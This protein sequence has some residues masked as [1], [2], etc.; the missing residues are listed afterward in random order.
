M[1]LSS[2][3]SINRMAISGNVTEEAF[4]LAHTRAVND[5]VDNEFE[6]NQD[7]HGDVMAWLQAQTQD[8]KTDE[9]EFIN[10][11]REQDE[12]YRKDLTEITAE[13][14]K[15][16][17]HSIEAI[18][19]KQDQR[20]SAIAKHVSQQKENL[21]LAIEKKKDADKRLFASKQALASISKQ[22]KALMENHMTAITN[23]MERQKALDNFEP[24]ARQSAQ[25]IAKHFQQSS[26]DAFDYRG[27]AF[28][29]PAKY[30]L[31][32][33]RAFQ[34]N[35]ETM[36][37]SARQA[38]DPDVRERI[39]IEMLRQKANYGVQQN[40][41]IAGLTGTSMSGNI[42]AYER[43]EQASALRAAELDLKLEA[44]G[45]KVDFTQGAAPDIRKVEEHEKLGDNIKADIENLKKY[46]VQKDLKESA[47]EEMV[48][49]ETALN[50]HGKQL[51][52]VE[53]D[54]ITNSKL[55]DRMQSN[56]SRIELKNSGAQLNDRTMVLVK[57][58]RERQE[59]IELERKQSL[60]RNQGMT[61]AR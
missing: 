51:T 21:K 30:A 24:Q 6:Y 10:S 38:R 25:D 5:A 17:R 11:G 18:Q 3:T 43:T 47:D 29:H 16:T 27:S 41:K 52:A 8:I 50:D 36:G 34:R 9:I 7:N 54:V 56:L 39:E 55:V 4:V 22:H 46:D 13:L 26:K 1:K 33:D 42:D 49:S 57:E 2:L 48:K 31:E 44:R 32:R 20:E 12:L 37:D 59:R 35:L 28:D 58:A 15:K 14:D 60:E 45:I 23:V 53:Q 40:S 19:L 61:Y